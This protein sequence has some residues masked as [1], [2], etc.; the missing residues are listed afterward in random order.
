MMIRHFPL[1][2]FFLSVW[3]FGCEFDQDLTY[4]PTTQRA[5]LLME[6]P[7]G[8]MELVSVAGDNIIRDWESSWGLESGAVSD[9]EWKDG[10]F[11]MAVPSLG[12]IWKI[13][14]EDPEIEER[15]AVGSMKPDW[16]CVG[17]DHLVFGDQDSAMLGFLDLNSG[18]TFF[19][20]LNAPVTTTSYN[21]QKFFVG[22]QSG[23]IEVW[24]E[25]AYAPLGSEIGGLS[26]ENLQVMETGNIMAF[27]RDS[28]GGLFQRILDFHALGFDDDWE[29]VEAESVWL[30]P[31]RIANHGKELTRTVTLKSG[32]LPRSTVRN[33][34]DVR[35]DFWEGDFYFQDSEYLYRFQYDEQELDTLSARIGPL[36]GAGFDIRVNAR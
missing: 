28:T 33:V 23:V 24:H 8:R 13:N 29:K 4:V 2:L 18:Q 26:L 16:L 11:W 27:G 35:V 20:K 34:L 22:T 3:L 10:A 6:H 31:Y 25:T 19:R 21:S 12:E 17:F 14:A 1:C 15:F 32:R 36:L 30:S 7:N 5:V 9:I